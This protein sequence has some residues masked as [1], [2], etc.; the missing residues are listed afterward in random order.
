[1][2]IDS[3]HYD[4]FTLFNGL[5][6]Q[7]F[8]MSH[9]LGF[10][11]VSCSRT[12][13]TPT[14]VTLTELELSQTWSDY[15]CTPPSLLCAWFIFNQS[16]HWGR[17]KM[18]AIP[19]DIFKCIFLNENAYISVKIS[20]KFVSK[21]PINNYPA[22]VQIMVLRRPGD[23]PL[24]EPMVVSV[25][26]HICVTRPQWVTDHVVSSLRFSKVIRVVSF[27][28]ILVSLYVP[29]SL[30]VSDNIYLDTTGKWLNKV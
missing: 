10:R 24:S 18:A 7:N 16:T 1:M 5:L 12:L 2:S 28:N 27:C 4:T 15:S 23:K 25:L 3:C 21:G 19:D 26:T 17:D 11:N 8:Q 22:L 9:R 29:R 6:N 13:N 30:L 14:R 20:L